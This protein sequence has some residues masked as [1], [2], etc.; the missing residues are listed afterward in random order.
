MEEHGKNISI[1][2]IGNLLMGDE[3]F[4]VHVIRYL[5]KNFLFPD[6]V[7]LVDCGTA[8]IY[9]A[10]VFEQSKM[11]IVVDA[12]QIEGKPGQVIRLNHGDMAGARIQSCMSPH[13]IGVLE[14]LEICRLRD[15]LP[16]QIEFYLLIPKVVE[17][18]LELSDIVRPRVMDVSNMIVSQLKEAG[19]EIKNA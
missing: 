1:I 15:R 8:G 7:E 5:E 6:Q 13:Q 4:G 16:E 2:G 14:V 10:P 19:L 17:P 12:A 11:A 3:G 9:M 18:G